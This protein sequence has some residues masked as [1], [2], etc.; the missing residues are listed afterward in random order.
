M[1][2]Y[3]G[4]EGENRMMNSSLWLNQQHERDRE[5]RRWDNFCGIDNNFFFRKIRKKSLGLNSNVLIAVD[6]LP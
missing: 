3:V 4:G 6:S 5:R 2:S 1:N